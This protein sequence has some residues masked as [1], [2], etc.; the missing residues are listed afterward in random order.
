MCVGLVLGCALLMGGALM[1]AGD[2]SAAA[3]GKRIALFMGPT[4]DKYLGAISKSIND[5]RPRRA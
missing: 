4:Q 2:A 5:T 1:A 3:D